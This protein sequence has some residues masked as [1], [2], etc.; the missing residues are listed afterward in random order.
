MLIFD[1][2]DG[3][4]ENK[5]IMYNYKIER[6]I[7]ILTRYLYFAISAVT[8]NDFFANS[9]KK[10]GA[11]SVLDSWTYESHAKNNRGGTVVD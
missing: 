2:N 4:S 8:I 1:I 6:F 5:I 3:F 7:Q 9:R 11:T 10:N